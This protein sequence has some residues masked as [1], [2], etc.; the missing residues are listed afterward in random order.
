MNTILDIANSPVALSYN[1]Y[2]VYRHIY[3]Y[4]LFQGC[5]NIFFH[6]VF[7]PKNKE[8]RSLPQ[9]FPHITKHQ[10]PTGRTHQSKT[11]KVLLVRL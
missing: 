4:N 3:H 9:K 2:T 7:N 6:H 8:P 11:I 10:A 1:L 5:A